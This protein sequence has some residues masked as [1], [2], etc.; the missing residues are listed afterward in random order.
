MKV[1][2][3]LDG[4]ANKGKMSSSA[5]FI[6][7]ALSNVSFE[8]QNLF[9]THV[10]LEMVSFEKIFYTVGQ[11]FALQDKYPRYKVSVRLLLVLVV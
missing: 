2:R 10:L 1:Q 4:F 7:P 3:N 9:L 11:K 5:Q 6:S 8:L